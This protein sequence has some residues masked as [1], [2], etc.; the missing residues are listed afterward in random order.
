MKKRKKS[1]EKYLTGMWKGVKGLWKVLKANEQLPNL[2]SDED[3]DEPTALS[4]DGE[5]EDSEATDIDGDH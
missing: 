1:R 4:D 3:G 5:A 2:R